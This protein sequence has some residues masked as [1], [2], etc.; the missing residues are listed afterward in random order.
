MNEC[1]TY[2]PVFQRKALPPT[3]WS[4]SEAKP[5]PYV[6]Y[7]FPIHLTSLPSRW[8]QQ[9]PHGHWHLCT[10]LHSVRY[11]KAILL[12]FTAVQNLKSYIKIVDSWMLCCM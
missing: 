8:R 4:K 1:G 11:Q 3:L 7:N 6:I 12:I 2:V 10:L 5:D 9:V